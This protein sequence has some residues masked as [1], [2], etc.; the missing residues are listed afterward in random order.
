MKHPVCI[1]TAII[2]PRAKSDRR[3][4]APHRPNG[5]FSTQK[6]RES[7]KFQQGN[8]AGMNVSMPFR[9]ERKPVFP[10]HFV[11]IHSCGTQHTINP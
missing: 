3:K 4:A 6:R 7:V 2:V 11:P 9:A 1:K 8:D 10:C 5:M